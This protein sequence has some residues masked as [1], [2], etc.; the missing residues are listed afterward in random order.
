MREMEHPRISTR[1]HGFGQNQ[2]AEFA[3]VRGLPD[4]DA[5]RVGLAVGSAGD[6]IL[7]RDVTEV[8]E[9]IGGFEFHQ[10]F[11]ELSRPGY[12]GGGGGNR[13]NDRRRRRRCCLGAALS[14]LTYALALLS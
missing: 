4:D 5:R 14:S 1:M 11:I 2:A 12:F 8:R 13:R 10:C 7:F 3:V 9:V 6:E